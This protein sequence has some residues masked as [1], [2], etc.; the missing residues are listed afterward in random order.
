MPTKLR[1]FLNEMS[2]EGNRIF[3]NANF[4]KTGEFWG[5]MGF[6]PMGANAPYN[7][8]T[9]HLYEA[10]VPEPFFYAIVDGLCGSSGLWWNYSKVREGISISP[11]AQAHGTILM[12]QS[13]QRKDAKDMLATVQTL[14]TVILN[15]ESDLEKLKEQKNA[16]DAGN[17]EQIKGIFVDNYGGPSRSW[18][19]IARAVPLVRT[20]LTWFYRIDEKNKGGQIAQVDASVKSEELNPAVANYLK[21]KIEEYWAWRESYVPFVQRTY[22]GILENL[23]QQR[24][25][26]QLYMRWAA[27]NIQEAENML[28]PYEEMKHTFAVFNEEFP[29]FG[30]KIY[31]VTEM[32]FDAISNWAIVKDMCAPW[33]PA[34]ACELTLA[35]NPDLPQWKFSR[36]AAFFYYGSI[37]KKKLDYLKKKMKTEQEDFL[38]LMK[39]YGRYSDEDLARMGL[40]PTPEEKKADEYY[41]LKE[42]EEELKKRGGDLTP[43]EKAHLRDLGVK[44]GREI[45]EKN[46]PSKE[47]EESLTKEL[48]DMF[49][50]IKLGS[51]NGGTS[52]PWHEVTGELEEQIVGAMRPWFYLFGSDL[53]DRFDTRRKRSDWIAQSNFHVFLGG[54]K[55]G[56]G[57]LTTD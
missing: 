13:Y 2:Y 12:K 3:D 55:R 56:M 57:M 54:Y 11:M 48:Q 5:S 32:F 52:R 9:L 7:N 53:I 19:A 46:L 40:G 18:T 23:R 29:Q 34:I 47:A 49:G 45:A 28:L 39:Q 27:K 50:G 43:E 36:V 41:S 20:A 22:N 8:P 31:S 6:A 17:E 21:R 33:S 1:D 51:G 24:A 14:K 26:M 25:N 30:G 37:H 16:F 35:Y 10:G 15:L 38:E 42:K 4:E 44:I